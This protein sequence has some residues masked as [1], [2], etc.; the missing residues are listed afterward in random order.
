MDDKM[1]KNKSTKIPSKELNIANINKK[2]KELDTKIEAKIHSSV[3]NDYFELKVDRYFKKTKLHQM[4]THIISQVRYANLHGIEIEVL[5]IP[6]SVLMM[7]K[8]FTSFG[9][10]GFPK[11]LEE[12]LAL[13]GKLMDLEILDQIS[14]VF[15]QDQVDLIFGT[16]QDTVGNIESQVE[17]IVKRMI[18]MEKA[19]EEGRIEDVLEIGEDDI[20]EVINEDAIKVDE[21]NVEEN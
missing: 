10:K 20:L 5:F 21:E 18:E 4:I 12:E 6:Y 1:K 3:I 19:F 13:L 15:P 9:E 17:D 14:D 11:T 2:M 7:M 8:Y 16:I